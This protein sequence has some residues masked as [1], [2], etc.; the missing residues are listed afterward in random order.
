MALIANL[1]VLVTNQTLN[2]VTLQLER[3]YVNPGGR[4]QVVKMM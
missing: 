2:G 4:V 1:I 3:V